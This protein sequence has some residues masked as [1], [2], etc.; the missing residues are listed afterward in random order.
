MSIETHEANTIKN[1]PN[2]LKREPSYLRISANSKQDKYKESSNETYHHH[3][4]EDKRF[5]LTPTGWM[6]TVPR[7]LF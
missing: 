6:V 2:F 7:S 1:F 5:S 3:T 4:A